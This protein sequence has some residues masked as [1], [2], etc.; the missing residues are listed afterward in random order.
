MKDDGRSVNNNKL[1]LL[2]WSI[3]AGTVVA[4][5]FASNFL[6]FATGFSP[7]GEILFISPLFCGFILGLLTTM[8]ELYHSVIAAII[9]TITSVLLII[10]ALFAPILFGVSGDFVGLYYV[11][12]IQ[13]MLI[14]IVLIF[15]VALVMTITGKVVGEYVLLG[16]IYRAERMALSK[17]TVKWYQ[18]LEEA[19]DEQVELKPIGWKPEDDERSTPEVPVEE[20][21]AEVPIEEQAEE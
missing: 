21:S 14:S 3:S 5:F 7:S 13:N 4:F 20:A 18:M 6:K 19:A 10:L 9:L 12:V 2:L 17:D 1:K 11:F 15:P 16:H 8:D